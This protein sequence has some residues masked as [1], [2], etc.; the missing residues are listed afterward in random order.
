MDVDEHPV[1]VARRHSARWLD[2]IDFDPAEH[3]AHFGCR[4]DLPHLGEP[5]IV[6]L[7][8]ESTLRVNFTRNTR[9]GLF[10]LHLR[11]YGKGGLIELV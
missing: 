9:R 6:P 5:A 7:A 2:E 4:E 3:C 10:S 1:L 8:I 11:Q